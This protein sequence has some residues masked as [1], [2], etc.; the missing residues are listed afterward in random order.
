M[1]RLLI[2]E[3]W[4]IILVILKMPVLAL[5][6]LLKHV[7]TNSY[8]KIYNVFNMGCAMVIHTYIKHF[9]PLI[10]DGFSRILWTRFEQIV[11]RYKSLSKVAS[12]TVFI[13]SL[14]WRSVCS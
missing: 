5:W 8:L 10:S 12:G 9:Q 11:K 14:V 4:N 3:T 1:I 7:L 2:F 6:V 13:A